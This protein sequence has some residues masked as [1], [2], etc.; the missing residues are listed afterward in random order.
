MKAILNIVEHRP[1]LLP[2]RPWIM[3]Q[4]WH[5]LLFAHWPID[6]ALLRNLI[7]SALTIDMFGGRAWVGV[8]PFLM[9]GVRLRGMPSLPGLS[10]FLELNVRTYVTIENKP[11]VWFFSLDAANAFAVAVAR[12][13]F[14]LP[15]YRAVMKCVCREG[16]IEYESVRTHPGASRG[17]LIARYRP[18]GDPQ[19]PPAGTLEHFLTERYC[20]YAVDGKGRILR[21]E[22]HHPPWKLQAA[23][24]AFA[25]NTVAQS[26]GVV[27]PASEPLL[28][29]SKFQEM[30]AWAPQVVRA[31][32]P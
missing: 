3:T 30:V 17:E 18:V 28:H 6:P 2:K 10:A 19:Q 13:W 11:G 26:D 8:V 9:T 4:R 22:I 27:P 29:F 23:E 16:A 21:G 15:Y 14:H 32:S 20:L 12:A 1:W 24:A 25:Q 5:D 7:P 31:V